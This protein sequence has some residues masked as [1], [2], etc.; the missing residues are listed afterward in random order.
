MIH[1]GA[2]IAAGISQGKTTTFGCDAKTLY[3]FRNDTEK[4]DFVNVGLA[5]GVAVSF[6]APIG[7]VLFTLE[8][9]T[10][11]LSLTLFCFVCCLFCLFLFIFYLLAYLFTGLLFVWMFLPFLALL[12]TFLIQ[13]A[14]FWNYELTWRTFFSGMV[15][16][17]ILNFFL[18]GVTSNVQWGRLSE[19]GMLLLCCVVVLSMVKI[20]T[21]RNK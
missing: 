6:G 13:G 20:K 4:R 2:I 18:S 3:N 9:S 12:L 7:G 19:A 5:A 16:T 21:N 14:S 17:F 10:F 11:F 1:S 15:A 8:Q